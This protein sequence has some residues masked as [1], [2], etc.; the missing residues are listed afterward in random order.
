M[1]FGSD[2]EQQCPSVHR[3]VICC[4]PNTRQRV[5]FPVVW[6]NATHSVRVNQTP[7]I[8]KVNVIQRTVAVDCIGL[9]RSLPY[10]AI[11]AYFFRHSVQPWG[12]QRKQHS[13][14]GCHDSSNTLILRQ[15]IAYLQK[16]ATQ[17]WEGGQKPPK[18]TKMY[19]KLASDFRPLPRGLLPA[20]TRPQRG[21]PPPLLL[22]PKWLYGT[23]G[24][25][26]AGDFV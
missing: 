14:A 2:A 7:L 20:R 15:A 9:W 13:S 3:C 23:L 18:I 6:P 24:F 25:V 22:T 10:F 4:A 12:T 1:Y 19:L 16:K 11:R 26:G 21:G 5:G 17:I 8:F